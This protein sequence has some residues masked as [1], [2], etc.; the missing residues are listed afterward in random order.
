MYLTRKLEQKMQKP[1]L[2]KFTYATRQTSRNFCEKLIDFNDIDW[3]STKKIDEQIVNQHWFFS[4]WKN[5]P[6][7]QSM[8][9]VLKTLQDKLEGLNNVWDKLSGDNPRIIF[10]LLSMNDLGLPDDLYIK[11]NARGKPLT[12]FEHFKSS[13]SEILNDDKGKYF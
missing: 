6:T 9:V 10:S 2:K 4:N 11:M 3:N 12:D 8:L 1:L 5:D 7:I 13:F